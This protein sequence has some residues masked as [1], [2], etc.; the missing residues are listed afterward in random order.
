M[1]TLIQPLEINSSDF[2]PIGRQLLINYERK[3]ASDGGIIYAKPETT[4]EAD[5]IRVGP[6][7]S[8]V[9]GDRIMM[10]VYRGENIDMLDGEFTIVGE[11]DV[12]CVIE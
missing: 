11:A 8:C 2:V 6:E 12:L 4:W 3:E 10:T 1:K 5:V 7:C 9:I